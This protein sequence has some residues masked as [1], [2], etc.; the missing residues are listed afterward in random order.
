MKK[1]NLEQKIKVAIVHDFQ[2]SRLEL[3]P[4]FDPQGDFDYGIKAMVKAYEELGHADYMIVIDGGMWDVTTSS[5]NSFPG[6][7]EEK[8]N[9]AGINVSV[10]SQGYTSQ[11][12]PAGASGIVES[13]KE[14]EGLDK[15]TADYVYV[16]F[17]EDKAEVLYQST[18]KELRNGGESSWVKGAVGYK[19]TRK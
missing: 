4:G 16:H 1:Q 15:L 11:G 19:L 3:L 7:V 10:E 5:Q 2:R 6:E 13:I 9:E 14:E 12:Y 8:M 18:C 17:R